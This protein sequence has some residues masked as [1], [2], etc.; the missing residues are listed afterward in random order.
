MGLGCVLQLFLGL[1]TR[2]CFLGVLLGL[3]CVLFPD[4]LFSWLVVFVVSRGLFWQACL[5]L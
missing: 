4:R 3:W 1:S 5:G 2:V